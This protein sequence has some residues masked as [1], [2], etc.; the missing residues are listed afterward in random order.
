MYIKHE[1][2]IGDMDT[3]NNKYIINI[4]IMEIQ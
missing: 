1:I 4:H 3:L 2:I